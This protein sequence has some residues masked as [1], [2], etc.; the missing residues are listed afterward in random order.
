VC[1]RTV[2]IAT[3]QFYVIRVP[4]LDLNDDERNSQSVWK[5][6]KNNVTNCYFPAASSDI[7]LVLYINL[8]I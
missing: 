2:R 8:Y 3:L 7:M 1:L 6:F 4:G 5:V